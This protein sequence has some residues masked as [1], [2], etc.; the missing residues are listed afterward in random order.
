ML[1]V[2]NLSF[3]FGSRVLFQNISFQ[4]NPHLAVR[5]AGP[6][7]SGKSTLMSLIAGLN[8]G[9]K[10]DIQFTESL[11]QGLD[12]R[13]NTA[14]LPADANALNGN[15]SAFDNLKFWMEL[16]GKTCT[17]E[18]IESALAEWGLH[19]NYTLHHLSVSHFSTGMKRRL[20][21]ARLCLFDAKL[22]LLDEPLFGL[23]DKACQ[24]FRRKLKLHLESGG[25]AV[26][27]T[28]DERLLEGIPATT[29]QLGSAS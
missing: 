18:T 13:H 22:W 8:S 15:L 1:N 26:V 16:R 25:A 12:V 4:A 14:W 19:G 9:A 21:L 17:K 20:A 7:G 2:R 11:S 28:H 27:V 10:G 5:L 23:D 29:V 6:N 24:Q 3:A